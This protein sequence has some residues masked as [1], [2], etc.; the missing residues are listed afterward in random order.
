MS[1]LP[2]ITSMAIGEA[3]YDE[4]SEGSRT[5]VSSAEVSFGATERM[6]I[7]R[8]ASAR[9][10]VLGRRP[11]G[12]R[13]SS[14]PLLVVRHDMYYDI[15]TTYDKLRDPLIGS[16]IIMITCVCS[17]GSRAT[18]GTGDLPISSVSSTKHL[19]SE[20]VCMSFVN[21]VVSHRP[22]FLVAH[23][24]YGFDNRS[25]SHHLSRKLNYMTYFNPISTKNESYAGFKLMITIPGVNNVDSLAY[26]R[27]S[28]FS[29]YQSYS[30]GSLAK[31]LGTYNKGS[32][33]GFSLNLS[34][35]D[36]VRMFEYNIGDCY[37]LRGICD[38][39][40]ILSEIVNLCSSAM[41][42]F[43]D[44]GVYKTGVI[45]WSYILSECIARG[46]RFRWPKSLRPYTDI[47]GGHVISNGAN[48]VGFNI[49][50]DFDSLY[51]SIMTLCNISP[52]NIRVRGDW[53][54]ERRGYS[55][56]LLGEFSLDWTAA[57]CTFRTGSISASFDSRRVKP[58]VMSQ[59]CENLVSSRR[60]CAA[61]GEASLAS[62]KK[63][64]NNSIYGAL[65]CHAY[66]SYSPICASCVTAAGRHAL[67]ILSISSL[68][69]TGSLPFYGDTDSVFI[70]CPSTN[71]AGS[72]DPEDGLKMS[73]EV[74]DVMRLIVSFTPLE[75]LNVKLEQ[76]KKSSSST[77]RAMVCLAPK[78]YGQLTME[79]DVVIKGLSV[80]RRD[81]CEFTNRIQ[82]DVMKV[83]LKSTEGPKGQKERQLAQP[84]LMSS[85]SRLV[86]RYRYELMSAPMTVLQLGVSS[87][88]GGVSSSYI[89]V[90][91]S[92]SK[93]LKVFFDRDD[94]IAR[95]SIRSCGY[96]I[97]MPHY[98]G[99]IASK[100][101]SITKA[102]GLDA[103][104]EIFSCCSR[105]EWA[106]ASRAPQISLR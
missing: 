90:L 64:I 29:V 56:R 4:S 37:A 97:D 88:R 104:H 5:G 89:V 79:D 93:S 103:G 75:G 76:S 2:D 92:N 57:Q 94:A 86:K 74:R 52:E 91:D 8:D 33:P 73:R 11:P 1:A 58:S 55:S 101:Q 34:K 72:Y 22:T 87:T 48:L 41:S 49:C 81:G 3:C 95:Q 67:E 36:Y 106:L 96:I 82:S 59:C 21:H 38:K 43:E 31:V 85:V 35:E 15:E 102:V 17:C 50:L 68:I 27:T 65:A 32:A 20:S 51:P 6:R 66:P 63:I 18:F 39:L 26:I 84:S 98:L 45:A 100:V 70:R 10:F 23:N 105:T 16:P 46:T 44:V 80:V 40:D 71:V 42:P 61:R 99:R 53:N 19:S 54:P 24:A 13:S 62:C 30:L 78:I 25:I 9:G 7:L 28:K 60:A 83:M 69:V 47:R 12:S 14:C 77:F